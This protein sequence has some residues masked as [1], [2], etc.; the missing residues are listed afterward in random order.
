MAQRT[1][2]MKFAATAAVAAFCGCAAVKDAREAQEAARPAGDGVPG[3]AANV[4]LGGETLD[5]LVAYALANRPSMVAARL[6]VEDAR[7][8]LR[9]IAADAPL[10]SSTPWNA[11]G[12]DVSMSYSEQSRTAHFDDMKWKTRRGKPSATLSLDV[13]IW[14]FGR[15]AARARAQA[16]NVVAA[17]QNL[18][19]AGCAVFDEVASCH[20]ALLQNE[21][22]AEVAASN[23]QMCAEHLVQEEDR[24]ELGES[25]SLDVLRARLDLARA[26]EAAV[27]AS[28][29]VVTAGANLMA[30]LG[31]D[32][33]SGGF[34]EVLGPRR[35]SLDRVTRVFPSTDETAADAFA[36]ARTNSP[37]VQV[38]RAK[39]RAASAQVDYA[40]ANLGPSLSAAVSLNWTDPL[41][42]WR[43]SVGAAQSLFTGWRKT[44][45]V[46]RAR[47]ALESA[48]AALGT[49]E[50]TLSRSLELA[51]AERDNA[52]ESLA[53]AAESVRQASENLET[54]AAQHEV[55]DASRIDYADAITSYAEALGN[56]V[57][58]F[59]RGQIAEARIIELTGREPGFANEQIT[60]GDIR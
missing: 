39:L 18:A 46:D 49:E 15:N 47:V 42:Y 12:A 11:V 6:A 2:M 34:R 51:I 24:F 55:G 25:R 48:S 19:K 23:V 54:V 30:A 56:R 7:L 35:E 50:Q 52:A 10:V 13:L 20:F 44:T 43:W 3:E 40:I 21:A 27:L 14:D 36:F 28:N 53:T 31:I 22:L 45:D 57:K 38:A 41:W 5:G 26:A 8:A 9:E 58:A 60:G 16:E 1:E 37:A 59:Y 4:Y 33:S 17:E 32:A 29:D